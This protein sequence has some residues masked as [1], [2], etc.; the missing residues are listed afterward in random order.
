MPFNLHSLY[1]DSIPP[2]MAELIATSPMQRL[3]RV[4]MNCGCEYTRSPVAM[5]LHP[6]SRLDH[7]IGAALIVWRFTHSAEQAVAA[8]FHDISTPCFAHTID[9]MLGDYR[10]QEATE[11]RTGQV[12]RSSEEITSVLAKYGID[13]SDVTNYHRYSIADNDGPRLSSDRLEYTCS[14]SINYEVRDRAD[15]AVFFNDI[16][17]TKNEDGE[18]ELA[19]IHADQA[20]IFASS[21]LSCSHVYSSDTDR[22]TMQMLAE[23]VKSALDAGLVTLEELYTL[24]ED[25]IIQRFK[26]DPVFR[27]LWMDYCSIK[28]TYCTAL[29]PDGLSEDRPGEWRKLIVKK[30]YIDPLIIDRGRATELFREYRSAVEDYLE[31]TM[32][33]W[34]CRL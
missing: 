29:L 6:Y 20:F 5:H 22:Y 32:D 31:S 16:A 23:L 7:S 3:D 25:V 2:F 30:R 15:V 4:G 10:K 19:F 14:N 21:S 8:L 33:Y 26:S 17:V 1:S 18:D 12:I 28:G 9:F 13:V 24:T 11:G 27:K 34:I